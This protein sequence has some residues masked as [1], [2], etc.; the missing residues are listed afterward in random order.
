MNVQAYSR[1]DTWHEAEVILQPGIDIRIDDIRE[2]QFKE[3][4][5][6]INGIHVVFATVTSAHLYDP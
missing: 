3:K 4:L 5:F 1:S 2:N 6:W